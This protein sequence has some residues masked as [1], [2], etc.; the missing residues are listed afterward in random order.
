MHYS[1]NAYIKFIIRVNR[2][3]HIV[4]RSICDVFQTQ[5]TVTTSHDSRKHVQTIS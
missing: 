5:S 3:C 2:M 4:V 1:V